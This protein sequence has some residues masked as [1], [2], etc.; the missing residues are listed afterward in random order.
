MVIVGC[1]F[2]LLFLLVAFS[3]WD[4]YCDFQETIKSTELQS[5]S[6]ARAL[7]EHAERT[8]S[9]VDL[10]VQSTARKLEAAGGLASLSKQRQEQIIQSGT[11]NT[12]QIGSLAFIDRAGQM[13]TI[14]SPHTTPLPK[15]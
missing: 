6:Y 14:S 11:V 4:S 3:I 12:P 10:V 13:Q 5:Q 8:F 1:V 9:E 2:S 7:K 15:W